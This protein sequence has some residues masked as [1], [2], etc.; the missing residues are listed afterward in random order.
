[1]ASEPHP[2]ARSEGQGDIEMPRPSAAPLTVALGAALLGLGVATSLAFL[3]VG[4]V[5]LAAGLWN[6]VA[7]LLPGE[8]HEIDQTPPAPPV[9]IAATPGS[10]ITFP[11]RPSCSLTTNAWPYPSAWA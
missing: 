6:W 8:G 1:M 3:V 10:S 9:L 2:V 11:H 7:E 4:A 5:V